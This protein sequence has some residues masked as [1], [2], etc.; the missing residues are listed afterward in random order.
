MRKMQPISGHRKEY[1]E[2]KMQNLEETNYT[3]TI[4]FHFCHQTQ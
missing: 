1:K 2:N 3:M 4:T